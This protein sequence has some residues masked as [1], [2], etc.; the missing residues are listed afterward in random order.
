MSY[1]IPRCANETLKLVA[2][3][4]FHNSVLEHLNFSPD[5]VEFWDGVTVIKLLE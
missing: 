4:N 5:K 1:K 3:Y 2:V